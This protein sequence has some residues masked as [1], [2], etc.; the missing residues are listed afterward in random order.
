[1]RNSKLIVVS[2]F[3]STLSWA[4]LA[5]ASEQ[6]QSASELGSPPSR[7]MPMQGG[8]QGGTSMMRGQQGRMP[9][10]QGQQGRMPMM[11]QMK[12]AHM[13]KMETH[14]A[15]IEALLKQLVELQTK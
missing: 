1:M 2:A 10:M 6:A 11:M 5:T 9:M 4:A 14:L 8:P 15:N 12:Q 3:A 7:A 13:K